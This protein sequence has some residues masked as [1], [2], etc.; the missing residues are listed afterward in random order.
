[1]ALPA[2][3]FKP[4]NGNKKTLNKKMLKNILETLLVIVLIFNF[5]VRILNK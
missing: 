5:E 1:V 2:C 4:L 3:A